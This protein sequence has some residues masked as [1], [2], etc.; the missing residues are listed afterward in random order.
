MGCGCKLSPLEK[1][2]K[3]IQVVGFNRLALSEIKLID[4][5]IMNKLGQSPTTPQDR[6]DLY[7][8]AKQTN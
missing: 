4:N 1:V 2:D 5:F 6:I 8:R 3:R 7:G